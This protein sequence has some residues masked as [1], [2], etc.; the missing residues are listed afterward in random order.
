LAYEVVKIHLRRLQ[1]FLADTH[2]GHLGY[3][4]DPIRPL[5][6]QWLWWAEA[7][8]SKFSMFNPS[9]SNYLSKMLKFGKLAEPS[10]CSVLLRGTCSTAYLKLKNSY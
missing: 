6:E 8:P 4:I 5:D 2:F 3:V 7:S 9:R 10:F 1:P